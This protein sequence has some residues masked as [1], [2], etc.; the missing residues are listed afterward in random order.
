MVDV[1]SSLKPYCSRPKFFALQD[2]FKIE[3]SC[4]QEMGVFV[5]FCTIRNR[6]G[7]CQA[8]SDE[9][10][11]TIANCGHNIRVIYSLA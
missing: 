5:P 8:E 4:P 11:E 3:G 9:L 10:S 2:S 6:R 7:L 1:L